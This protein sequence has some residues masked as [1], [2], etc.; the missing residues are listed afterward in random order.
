MQKKVKGY[1]LN[2]KLDMTKKFWFETKD[3]KFWKNEA[4]EELGY[5]Y[6]GGNYLTS[7]VK[8]SNSYTYKCVWRTNDKT[9]VEKYRL[10][11]YG[12][13]I[14]LRRSNDGK[15][16]WV[17][18]NI[19]NSINKPVLN[20]LLLSFKDSYEIISAN[21]FVNGI[22]QS[23][24]E[25][26]QSLVSLDSIKKIVATNP[27]KAIVNIVHQINILSLMAEIQKDSYGK[28]PPLLYKELSVMLYKEG[29]FNLSKYY[30]DR[31]LML[32]PSANNGISEDDFY[33]AN[34]T[35]K[36]YNE[37]IEREV[38]EEI[39]NA[40]N[41]KADF[42]KIE[43][44]N[45]PIQANSFNSI[46]FKNSINFDKE[47]NDLKNCS[48]CKGKGVEIEVNHCRACYGEGV[49]K[50]RCSR[51]NGNGQIT[52]SPSCGGCTGTGTYYDYGSNSL[53]RC[54]VSGCRNGKQVSTINCRYCSNGSKTTTCNYCSGKGGDYKFKNCSNH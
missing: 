44:V 39:Q 6:K 24:T 2:G 3:R 19:K 34:G 12:N 33:M 26:K 38:P 7:L 47:I 21:Y 37:F 11:P 40:I 22:N 32:K 5:F 36:N 15:N 45:N 30:L 29:Y 43:L 27:A 23:S 28:V 18:G 10:D 31:Y 49:L 52:I 14:F 46:A 48:I 20:G 13:K 16:N 9:E 17:I 53:R 50:T 25:A 42:S 54:T 1:F 35:F 8:Q 4:G 51:C 41:L